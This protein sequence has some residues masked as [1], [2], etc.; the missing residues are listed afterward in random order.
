[1]NAPEN[2]EGIAVGDAVTM[3]VCDPPVGMVNVEGVNVRSGAVGATTLTKPVKPFTPVADTVSVTL[4]PGVTVT[5][6]GLTVRLKSGA[7]LTLML[8]VVVFV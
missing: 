5:D 8:T 3:T 2:V 4:C 1:M 6:A 7:A